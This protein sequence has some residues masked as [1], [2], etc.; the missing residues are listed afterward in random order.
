M[1]RLPRLAAEHA[2]RRRAMSLTA[3]MTSLIMAAAIVALTGDATSRAD[4]LLQSLRDPQARSVVIRTSGPDVRLPRSAAM[5][6]AALAGVERAIALF[7]VE[8]VTSPGL[9]D[10]GATA[11][12]AGV[13]VLT[14]TEPF[15][16]SS[17]RMPAAGE[18]IVPQHTVDALRMTVPLASIVADDR[19][20]YGVVGVFATHR[21]GAIAA[22]LSN[23]AVTVGSSDSGYSVL[24]LLV[25]EPADVDTVVSAAQQLLPG[26]NDITVDAEPRAAELEQTVAAAGTNNLTAIALTIVLVGAAIQ[27]A[28]AIL[29]AILQRRE[30]AR[31]RAL[32]FSRLEIVSISVIEALI[33]SLVGAALGVSLAIWRLVA[34]GAPISAG[35][36]A[37]TV[38]LLAVTSM[39]AALPG[40]ITSAWQDPAR[41]LRVP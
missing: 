18:V 22:T 35:Q 28:Q 6:I 40:G 41:L 16:L 3:V 25:R 5:T 33:L 7:D 13:D 11:A 26:R 37:A 9:H 23:T 27:L 14:G 2:M 20:G 34:V 12:V 30:N 10:P 36:N 21:L 1:M 4:K 8:S 19:R 24:E 17:G 31:R 29:G 15:L 38:G 32:G 39:L